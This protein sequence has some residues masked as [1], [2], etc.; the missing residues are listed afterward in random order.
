VE[1]AA[2]LQSSVHK[3]ELLLFFTLL[4][5]T[6]IVLASRLCGNLSVRCGNSRAVGEIAAGIFLGPSLFGLLWPGGFEF[7]FRSGPPEPMT[8]LSQVGLI[9]LL[10][11][12]GMEFDF[13]HLRESRNWQ[14][15]LRIALVGDLLPFALGFAFGQFSAAQVFP[16]GNALGYSLFCGTA[17]SITAL[18]VL[19]RIMLELDLHRSKV[20]TVAI[21][22]AAINDVAGWLLLAVV[23][24]LAVAH[25]SA[26]AFALK[27][28]TLA[29]YVGVC[30]WI[31]RPFLLKLIRRFG[32]SAT[33]LPLDLLGILLATAFLSGIATYKIGIFAIF[34]GFMMG[35]LLHEQRELAAAWRER[36]GHFVNVF[37]VPIFFT[38]TG[39]RTDIGLLDGWQMWG[40]A[41]LLL[42]LATLGKFGGCYWAARWAGIGAAEAR[43][44]GII[45]NTRALM[46]LIVINVGYDLGV[47]PRSVFTMLVIMALVSTVVTTPAL[48]RWLRVRAVEEL[49]QGGAA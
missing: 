26:G 35:V 39:L 13:A 10:F 25:F 38:Y 9:L 40:W 23:S 44:I 32:A 6:V 3:A 49:K 22:A 37:F 34:G 20:G 47:I 24:A 21:S 15:V 31:V 46:E 48:K 8:I 19:G 11:Q 27:V 17:F 42:A 14:A 41:L 1:T 30:W 36:A 7:V 4:Q 16:Q 45:M 33:S 18:P 2:Q 12:I 28:A 43:A 29:I 5:L